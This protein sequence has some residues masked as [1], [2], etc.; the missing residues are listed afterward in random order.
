MFPASSCA[1]Q[2]LCVAQKMVHLMWMQECSAI[3]IPLT[4][5]TDM[6]CRDGLYHYYL[7]TVVKIVSLYRS[8]GLDSLIFSNQLKEKNNS[9]I[10]PTPLNGIQ[11]FIRLFPEE[12]HKCQ[13]ANSLQMKP[14]SLFHLFLC[15]AV[16]SFV[17]DFLR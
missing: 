5:S 11:T 12:N 4:S 2:L 17:V 1:K 9:F 16:I 15:L 7:C 10:L 3:S 6:Y 8:A 14:S 13:T